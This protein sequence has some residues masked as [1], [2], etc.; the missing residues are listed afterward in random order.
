[1]PNQVI[2]R[3]QSFSQAAGKDVTVNGTK[4]RYYRVGAGPAVFWLTGGLRRAAYGFAF[5]E[6]LAQRHTVIAPDYPTAQSLPE[7]VAG[8]DAILRAEGVERFTLGCQSYGGLLAQAYLALNPGPVERLLISSSGPADYGVLWYPVDVLLA[9]LARVLP[10]RPVKNLLAGGL[11]KVIT[12]PEAERMEWQEAFR[13][14]MDR[15]L[16]RADVVSHFAVAADIIRRRV[17]RPGAYANWPGRVVIL[18]AE[19]DP[20]Q[21]K[22]DRARFEALFGRPVE[23]VSLGTMGHTAVLFDPDR[24]V[25]LLEQALA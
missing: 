18:S 13:E 7:F 1:M 9:F 12:A 25:E 22:G 8:F 10:E 4:W 20:T 19:N 5:M 21:G 17:V 3:M 6:R 24:Y 14:T 11:M 2:A 16:T 15:D 23:V